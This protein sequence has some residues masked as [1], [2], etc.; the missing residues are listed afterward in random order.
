MTGK[1]I[2]KELL[3]VK[4]IRENNK[5]NILKELVRGKDLTRNDLAKKS[6]ISLMTV[7]HIV[8]DLVGDGIIEEH[9]SSA[10]VGR[11]PKALNISKRYGNIVCVN[12]TSTQSM[13]YIVYDLKRN[14]LVQNTLHFEAQKRIYKEKLSELLGEIKE[15]LEKIPTETV[16]IGVSV[17]SAYYE[18]EDLA[19]YDLIPEF[20]DFH[21]RQ[22]FQEQFELE[23][24]EVVHDVVSAAKSEY[25]AK[26]VRD[27]SLFYLYCGFGVGGCFVLRGEAVTGED[28]LA[29]EVGKIQMNN[30]YGDGIRSLEE[31]VSVPGILEK[32]HERVPGLQ[33]EEIL[34]RYREGDGKIT[35]VLNKALE[36]ISR[37]LY[38][39]VWLFNPTKFVVDSCYQDYA[40]L[41]TEKGR[42]YLQCFRKEDIY[43]TT[44]VEQ[45]KYDEY[46]EMRGCFRSVLQKWMENIACEDKEKE[47]S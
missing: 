34:Q 15:E 25:E 33:F 14:V 20:K 4:N 8:D 6:S 21:I 24:V 44:E 37:V 3:T 16:G 13:S 2:T 47:I 19:N 7:K 41:I 29:G 31:I 11:K 39:L 38:N 12:L 36:S 10:S 43:V 32:V 42:E 9:A 35:P 30:P 46:H 18:A 26:P 1:Q 23:N 40:K 45:T 17:P 5:T 22:F 27:D 28:L